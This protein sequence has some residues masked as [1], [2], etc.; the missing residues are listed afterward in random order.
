VDDSCKG[1]EEG[2]GY[3]LM[4]PFGMDDCLKAR[5]IRFAN[6]MDSFGIRDGWM[7]KFGTE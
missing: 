7:K 5:M 1:C 3:A 6:G 4:N 2:R